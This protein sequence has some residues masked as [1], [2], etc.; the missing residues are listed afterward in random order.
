MTQ[1]WKCFLMGLGAGIAAA[2]VGMQV[3]SVA[4]SATI[5]AN[6]QPTLLRPLT[7]AR[8]W[9]LREDSPDSLPKPWFPEI[10]SHVDSNWRIEPMKGKPLTLDEFKGKVL[11]LNFWSTSCMPC[12]EEMPGLIRLKASLGEP[13]IV[14]AA[15]T[16]DERPQVEDFLKKNKVDLPVY[17]SGSAVPHNLSARGIPTTYILNKDGAVVFRNV[18]PLN[19]NV[20]SARIYLRNLAAQK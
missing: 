6:S 19:W 17:L 16:A 3:W 20:E 1:G 7:S 2:L 10:E 14:F 5:A 15:I 8:T 18:G 13:Q 11:F 9:E 4:L 12:I